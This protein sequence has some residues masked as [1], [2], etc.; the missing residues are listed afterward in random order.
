MKISSQLFFRAIIVEYLEDLGFTLRSQII[1]MLS[2]V[3]QLFII[4]DFEN[5][6][7]KVGIK[8]VHVYDKSQKSDL[9]KLK[10]YVKYNETR[11]LDKVRDAVNELLNKELC[12]AK[13]KGNR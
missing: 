9:D 3:P 12:L 7:V 1:P 2:F 13:L 11:S 10:V 5:I 8:T 6:R 4:C